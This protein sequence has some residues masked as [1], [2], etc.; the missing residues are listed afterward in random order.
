MIRGVAAAIALVLIAGTANAQSFPVKSVTLIVPF[1]AGGST[2][3]V[4]RAL[5][6]ATQKHLGQPV[7]IENRPGAGGAL[8]P[9]QMASTAAPDGYTVAQIPITV[10]RYPFLQKTTFD[11]AT[12]LTYILGLTG[13]TFGVAVKSDSPWQTFQEFI[14][15]AKIN[16]GKINYG[17]PGAGTSLHIGMEQIAKLQGVKWTHVPFKGGADVINA[18]LGGHISADADSTSWAP[19]V[20]AGQFRLL[21]TWGATRTKNWPAVPT[22]KEIGINLVANSPF[23]I[24]GPKGI[25]PRVVTAL[26]DA[27]KKGMEEPSYIAEMAKFDQEPFYLNS[28]DYREYAVRT[29]AEQKRI[30]AD[31]GLS[32]N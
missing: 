18:L 25:D 11:P 9:M 13:Y 15:D 2:D 12:D 6:N 19:Q 30:L 32:Q 24:A 10:F 26:H 31:L 14:A 23:G 22:L 17:T 4:M 28:A 1:P 21:V 27:F 5:A 3:L 8:S 16:P 29:L 20:N 7:M